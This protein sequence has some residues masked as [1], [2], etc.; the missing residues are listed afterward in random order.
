MNGINA[1]TL[2]V[3]RPAPGRE[4][5]S[6]EGISKSFGETTA[7]NSVKFDLRVGEVHALIGENGAGK[8]TLINIMAGT[9]PADSGCFAYDGRPVRGLTPH[10]AR[11]AGIRPV[12]QEFSLISD[13]S[14]EANLFLGQEP[15]RAGLIRPKEM[16]QRA[17]AHLERIG[18][19]IDPRRTVATLS[20]AEQQMV[21]IAKAVLGD[22]RV[23]ILDEPTASLSEGE[24]RRLFALVSELK[25]AGVG[26]IYVSHRMA[27]IS[28]ISDRITVLRDGTLVGTV[29]NGAVSA[30]DLIEMMTGRR[31]DVLFPKVHHKPNA[32]RLDVEGL[33][34]VDEKL[35]DVSLHVQGGE[36]VGLAG[37]VGCGKSE[38]ARAM[39]GL[40]ALRGGKIRL[41][42]LDLSYA[43]TPAR[44]LRAGI[45]YFPSDRVAEG[46][47]LCRPVRE[48]GSIAALDLPSFV[49][50]GFVRRRAEVV[51]ILDILQRL[52]FRPLET[53]R[54]V[55]AL[56]GG[57]RQKVLFTRAMT[58][59]LK[60]FLFD[61]PTVGIDVGAKAEV[62]GTLR[63]LAESGAGILL[64]SSELPEI[65]HLSHRVYVLREGRVVAELKGD[66]IGEEQILSSIFATD[67]SMGP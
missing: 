55:S 54:L 40:E 27:E 53:E 56:S 36:I 17:R 48:N 7:L 16:R 52:R 15:G 44:M 9:F 6:L 49:R 26:I 18:F 58:R 32:T 60:M 41:D 38:V 34:T 47:A 25:T 10:R 37:L 31:I 33:T 21:E 35:I 59:D 61:E 1:P 28:Q 43:P 20:R 24:T 45:C 67:R 5:L 66:E 57:N 46:L 2:Q 30:S 65:V 4:I 62:Y 39:F 64:I 29:E 63:D 8:S 51:R 3:S 11:L 19:A 23:L 42:R 12:F 14:V 50:R 22:V 13:L